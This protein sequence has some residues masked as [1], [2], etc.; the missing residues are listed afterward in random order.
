MK[1]ASNSNARV[2]LSYAEISKLFRVDFDAGKLFW[3]VRSPEMFASGKQH[4]EHNCASWNSRYA[5]KEALRS[6][7]GKGYKVGAIYNRMYSAHRVIWML[8]YGSW[9]NG[10]IDHIN[11]D[12]SDNRLINLRVVSPVENS[13]NRG[14]PTNNTSGAVGVYWDKQPGKWKAQVTIRGRVKHIGHYVDF[15]DAV[16]AR[17]AAEKVYGF[18][19]NHGRLI[20][21]TREGAR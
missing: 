5:G 17:K 12:P 6:D 4:R 7:D 16:D 3:A 18:H 10:E 13:M 1:A 19:E 21:A 8:K 9:P 20:P 14:I 2:A 15:A 11:G